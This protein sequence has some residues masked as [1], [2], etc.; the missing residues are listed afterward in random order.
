V[1]G[2]RR[3][4]LAR[5]APLLAP[6]WP[7]DARRVVQEPLFRRA[8]ALA[9]PHGRVLNAGSGR[10]SLYSAFLESF[11]AVSEI[12]NLDTTRP[13]T[14]ARRADPRHIDVEGSVTTIPYE[15]GSFDWLLCSN[16]LPWVLADRAAA[17]ELGRVL[18]PGAHAL[19][20]V[21][22]PDAPRAS[23]SQFNVR[24]GYTLEQ[25]RALLAE[26]E[27]EI[28]WHE[29]GFYLPM[30]LL[31]IIWRWQYRR[32]GRGRRSLMPRAAVLA[33]GY[34]DRWLRIGRPWDLVVLARRNAPGTAR[35]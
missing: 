11:G 2:A 23:R 21:R 10:L 4:I 25:L 18:R 33:F 22:T 35:V 20:S 13:E 31:G 28:V 17:R 6:G 24:D 15:S 19:I 34:A 27:L 32:L 7:D 16:V 8:A 26:A 29:S 3:P 12:V 1:L 30:T 5:L 14:S 9:P